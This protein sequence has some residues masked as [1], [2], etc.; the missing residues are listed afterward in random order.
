MCFRETARLPLNYRDASPV[1]FSRKWIEQS[2][3]GQEA[4]ECLPRRLYERADLTG[5]DH[6]QPAGPRVTSELSNAT[7]ASTWRRVTDYLQAL[8][9][10]HRDFCALGFYAQNGSLKPAL[11][12]EQNGKSCQA[13]AVQSFWRTKV[14]FCFFFVVVVAVALHR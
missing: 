8:R 14:V 10:G 1:F 13:A 7:S 2:R 3:R 5:G 6:R 9:C 12:L 4:E 11:L